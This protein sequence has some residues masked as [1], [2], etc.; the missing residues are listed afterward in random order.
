VTLSQS[1]QSEKS[2]EKKTRKR[3]EFQGFLEVPLMPIPLLKV[4]W[5]GSGGACL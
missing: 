1:R 5:P 2:E 4:L 3:K